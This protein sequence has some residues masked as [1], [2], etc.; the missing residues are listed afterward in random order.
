MRGTWFANISDK[1]MNELMDEFD[2]MQMKRYRSS[3]E[4]TIPDFTK[5]VL[6][7]IT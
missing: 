7:S 3:L 5:R 1:D 2:V 4:Q 6:S